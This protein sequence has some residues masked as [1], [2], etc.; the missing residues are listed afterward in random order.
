MPTFIQKHIA[1]GIASFAAHPHNNTQRMG[2]IKDIDSH[3]LFFTLRIICS[4]SDNKRLN[5][6]TI[7]DM[8]HHITCCLE[9]LFDHTS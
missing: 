6:A 1:A 4:S 7:I 8:L 9:D 3:I 2:K 5:L